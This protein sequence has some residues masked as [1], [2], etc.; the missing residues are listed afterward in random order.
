MRLVRDGEQWKWD[1][2]HDQSP[3]AVE[4]RMTLL[5][6]KGGT[7]DALSAEVRNGTK[8]NV[9]EILETIQNAKP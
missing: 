5:R 3:L 1:C 2:F 8:T 9:A 4:Q 7:F 6:H